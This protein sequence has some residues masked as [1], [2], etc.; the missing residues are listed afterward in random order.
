[1]W[2]HLVSPSAESGPTDEKTLMVQG[3]PTAPEPARTHTA[4]SHTLTTLLLLSASAE[5]ALEGL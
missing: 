3:Q 4:S 2:K 1:M 5:G